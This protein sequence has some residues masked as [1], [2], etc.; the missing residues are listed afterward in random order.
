MNTDIQIHKAFTSGN[1]EMLLK[2]A[3][4]IPGFPDCHLSNAF[5]HCLEYAIYHSPIA[6]ISGLLEKGAKP[7]Y[8]EH[9]GFPCIIAALSSEREDVRQIVDLLLSYGAD[10]NQRG[11]NDWTPLHY[12]AANDDVAMVRFLLTKGADP[13]LRTHI[14]DY[15]TPLEEAKILGCTKVIKILESA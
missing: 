5:G 4:D 7:D 14:D 2:L 6:F 1:F 11:L 9:A 10:I 15:A 12:A 8:G 3:G 13:D